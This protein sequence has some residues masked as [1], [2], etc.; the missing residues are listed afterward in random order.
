MPVSAETKAH[1]DGRIRHKDQRACPVKISCACTHR[2]RK[3]N[4]LQMAETEF[5]RSC[6]ASPAGGSV[7]RPPEPCAL[8]NCWK[9][10]PV[11]VEGSVH[12]WGS[13][14]H[15]PV[16]R[17]NLS[18]ATPLGI[19]FSLAAYVPNQILL[20]VP[21]RRT[22]R[23]NPIRCLKSG[24]GLPGLGTLWATSRGHVSCPD[25]SN[26]FLLPHKQP[27]CR[28]INRC[29]DPFGSCRTA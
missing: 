6:D 5:D 1:A 22:I 10:G 19:R 20:S 16:N 13:C 15:L 26:D 28:T 3:R 29:Q 17:L 8:P 4:L 24:Q 2:R 7:L 18:S 23:V 25:R 12:R 14:L 21:G 27:S 9:W 11:G